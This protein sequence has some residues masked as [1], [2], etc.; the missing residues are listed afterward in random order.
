MKEKKMYQ[1]CFVII[2][3]QT[4]AVSPE[5]PKNLITKVESNANFSV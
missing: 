4:Q 5:D 2:C 1:F 3:C